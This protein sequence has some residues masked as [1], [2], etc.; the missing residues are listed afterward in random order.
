M[1]WPSFNA[2]KYLDERRPGSWVEHELHGRVR[3]WGGRVHVHPDADD[4][5]ATL[6]ISGTVLTF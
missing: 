1:T 6:S 2:D 3:Y 5:I 4:I